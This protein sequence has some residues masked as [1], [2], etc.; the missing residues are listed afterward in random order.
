MAFGEIEY[1]YCN[2]VR[3]DIILLNLLD[4]KGDEDTTINTDRF[5]VLNC[6]HYL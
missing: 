2:N 6:A 3:T 5:Q 1:S 4:D